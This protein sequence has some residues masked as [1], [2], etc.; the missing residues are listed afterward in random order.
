[1]ASSFEANGN[2]QS[3]G[4]TPEKVVSVGAAPD[5]NQGRFRFTFDPATGALVVSPDLDMK[6][7]QA[8][9]GEA[10]RVKYRLYLSLPL[11]HLEKL[12]LECASLSLKAVSNFRGYLR[13][14]FLY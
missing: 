9:L 5:R 12:W 2:V 10:R 7:R 8:I 1:M 6:I 11:L 3:T 13:N 14:R 4:V